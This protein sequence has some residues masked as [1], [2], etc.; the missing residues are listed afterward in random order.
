MVVREIRSERTKLITDAVKQFYANN[1]SADDGKPIYTGRSAAIK[2]GAEYWWSIC[3]RGHLTK[4]RIAKKSCVTC[5]RAADLLRKGGIQSDYAALSEKDQ[6]TIELIYQA[7]REL[8]EKSGRPYHVDHWQPITAGGR[9]HPDNLVITPATINLASNSTFGGK[10][11]YKYSAAER[12]LA[13]Q[14]AE[15]EYDHMGRKR[16]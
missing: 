2:D 16:T 4:R 14:I 3:K 6:K 12:K 5:D 11:K 1:P 10:R 15:T 13:I 8:G 9:H 7:A